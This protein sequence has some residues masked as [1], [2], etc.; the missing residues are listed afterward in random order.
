MGAFAVILLIMFVLP[1]VLAA[2]DR[3]KDSP[4]TPESRREVDRAL[5][6]TPTNELC[7]L[8]N[9]RNQQA[10]HC[11]AFVFI[12]NPWYNILNICISLHAL[13]MLYSYCAFSRK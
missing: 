10:A 4:E 11:A 9:P 13:C 8:E 12:L 5:P 2:L 7:S 1:G 3:K 6:R